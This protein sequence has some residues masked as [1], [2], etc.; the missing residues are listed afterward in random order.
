MPWP[1]IRLA[2]HGDARMLGH[3][4]RTIWLLLARSRRTQGY[5]AL[6]ISGR[7][8]QIRHDLCPIASGPWR[9]WFLLQPVHDFKTQGLEA[10]GPFRLRTAA[11]ERSAQGDGLDG[12]H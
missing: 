7:S 2:A 12:E 9:A 10:P 3:H 11:R 5:D 4:I 1:K 8:Q 6:R